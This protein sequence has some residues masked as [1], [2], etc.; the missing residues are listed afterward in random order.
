MTISI[1]CPHDKEKKVYGFG[2]STPTS[3]NAQGAKPLK[4]MK[5]KKPP[6]PSS[7]VA[8]GSKP[9]TPAKSKFL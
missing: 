8:S 4:L 9:K 1:N 3:R 7:R 5:P 2:V 6:V